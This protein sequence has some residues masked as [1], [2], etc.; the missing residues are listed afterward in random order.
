M[1]TLKIKLI[2]HGKTLSSRKSVSLTL[3]AR[4]ILHSGQDLLINLADI[5]STVLNYTLKLSCR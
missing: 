1:Y 4:Y 3:N 2:S 5:L